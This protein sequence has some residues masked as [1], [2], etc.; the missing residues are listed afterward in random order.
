[1]T[2]E[3]SCDNCRFWQDIDPPELKQQMGDAPYDE[4]GECRRHA[5][6][7]VTTAEWK[8]EFKAVFPLTSDF[9]WCGEWQ[10]KPEPEELG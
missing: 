8:Q 9:D 1:M 2:R 4:I 3:P 10:Q 5:P 7:P 6:Q